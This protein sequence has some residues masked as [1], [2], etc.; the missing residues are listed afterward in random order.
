MEALQCIETRRSIRNFKD[1]PVPHEVLEK[2]VKEASYAPSWKNTQVV[3]YVV[4]EDKAIQEKMAK[5]L[6]KRLNST[7]TPFKNPVKR[8]NGNSF[9]VG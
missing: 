4:V 2:I 8:R 5:A 9:F 7:H 3:R 6:R 1:T